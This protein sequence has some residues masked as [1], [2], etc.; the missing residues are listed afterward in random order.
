LIEWM[1]KVYLRINEWL[2]ANVINVGIVN[3]SAYG[4]MIHLGSDG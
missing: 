3:K 1:A 2:C 4:V